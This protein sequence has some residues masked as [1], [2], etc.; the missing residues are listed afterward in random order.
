MGIAS[1]DQQE[2][3]V[4]GEEYHGTSIPALDLVGKLVG[5][6]EDGPL[7]F[8]WSLCTLLCLVL[9]CHEK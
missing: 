6:E 8:H 3:G 7:S 4:W 5:R 9:V 1:Q 2:E